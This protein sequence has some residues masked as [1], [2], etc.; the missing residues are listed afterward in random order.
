MPQ[1]NQ[2]AP[3]RHARYE[4]TRAI[5]RIDDPSITR[6]A[7][8]RTVFFAEDGVSRE[9]LLNCLDDDAFRRAIGH[10]HRIKLAL[11][12]IFDRKR[13]TKMRQDRGRR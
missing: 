6:R 5:D 12:L 4:S 10:R 11:S 8:A 2:R 1:T 9:L 13:R 7:D 3:G